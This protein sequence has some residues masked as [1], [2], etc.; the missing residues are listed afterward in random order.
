MRRRRI[1]CPCCERPFRR[2]VDYP[3]VRVQSFERLPLPEAV[4][5][6]SEAAAEKWLARRRQANADDR[7]ELRE[8]GINM[9]PGN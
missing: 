7:S 2:V 4:D 6:M 9:T 3:R 1:A 8:D 5:T